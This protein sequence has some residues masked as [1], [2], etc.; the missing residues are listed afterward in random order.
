MPDHVPAS[1]DADTRSVPGGR[2]GGRPASRA[3]RWRRRLT[4]SRWPMVAMFWA[5]FAET[6]IVPIPI[7]VVLIPFM[8]AR[9]HQIW[10]IATVVTV[11]CLLASMVGYGI[12]YF[13][14]A[15][16]GQWLID[17]LGAAQ[18]F[19]RFQ[20]MF[21]DH[22][23]LAILAIGVVPI[24]FQVAML[25]AGAAKYPIVLF[26]IAATIARGIR[27]FGLALLVLLVGDRAL[28]LW[29]HHSRTAALIALMA[30]VLL[31]IGVNLVAGG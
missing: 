20:E 21:A 18:D 15:S 2:E 28:A 25:A 31:V 30:V 1:E 11:G 16:A 17:A 10:W 27:Y 8:I 9:R 4:E 13:F 12:G 24:P 29:R 7:E 23:F 26:V 5:S 6:I 19:Q 22:G 14:F 3:E